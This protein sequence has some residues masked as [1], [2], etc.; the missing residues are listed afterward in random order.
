M[1]VRGTRPSTFLQ[2]VKACVRRKPCRIRV[3]APS[4]ECHAKRRAQLAA[5]R[6]A[7]YAAWVRSGGDFLASRSSRPFEVQSE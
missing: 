2:L 4:A 5:L 6:E 7:D 1:I 3:S